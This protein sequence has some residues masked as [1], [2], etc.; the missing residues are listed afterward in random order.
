MQNLLTILSDNYQLYSDCSHVN[1]AGGGACALTRA[2]VQCST[3]D[4]SQVCATQLDLGNCYSI[5]IYIYRSA[6]G[7]FFFQMYKSLEPN[8]KISI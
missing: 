4:M 8:F 2:D 7:I 3:C 6:T 5:V 1:R